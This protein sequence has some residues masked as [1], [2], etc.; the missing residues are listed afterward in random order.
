[1]HHQTEGQSVL[2][3]IFLAM[4]NHGWL[5][6]QNILLKSI[7]ILY[8]S[9]FT[10]FVDYSQSLSHQITLLTSIN[11]NQSISS[12]WGRDSWPPISRSIPEPERWVGPH[13][14]A[15][16]SAPRKGSPVL[17]RLNGGATR[18]AGS[19][20]PKNH[21]LND[22]THVFWCF[23]FFIIQNPRIKE[24]RWP[25][26]SPSPLMNSQRLRGVRLPT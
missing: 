15:G 18:S 1:M 9:L 22:K 7:N 26:G 24:K 21:V 4:I 8:W 25:F 3:I 23:M 12:T 17:S 14:L 16:G 10:T 20:N 11:I 5:P 6:E 13:Q 19:Q 2:T